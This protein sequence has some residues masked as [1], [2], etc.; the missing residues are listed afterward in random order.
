[1][2]RRRKR[3][4]SARLEMEALHCKAASTSSKPARVML[5]A[6]RSEEIVELCS[7]S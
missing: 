4:H 7:S 5:F 6:C 3:T 2:A 1:M